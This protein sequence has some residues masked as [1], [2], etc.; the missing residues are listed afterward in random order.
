MFKALLHIKMI[1]KMKIAMAR[2]LVRILAL[3]AV[4]LPHLINLITAGSGS[5]DSLDSLETPGR[6]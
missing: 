5:L 3:G 1:V 6:P 4:Q 2:V